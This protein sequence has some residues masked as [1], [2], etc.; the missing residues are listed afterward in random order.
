MKASAFWGA[1]VRVPDGAGQLVCPVPHREQARV[2]AWHDGL[3]PGVWEALLCWAK[4]SAKSFTAAAL[5][6]H[7][8]VGEDR[9]PDD[10]LIGI[11]SYD[12]EQSRVIF[13]EVRR[14]IERAPILR[15][16]LRVLRNEIV[17]EEVATDARTGGRYTRD[18][19]LRV[20]SRDV[21]GTHGEPWSM[22]IR[23]E[24][25]SEPNHEMSEALIPS[26]ARR[27]ACT[28]S[29]SYAGLATMQKPG[30]P[31]YD[32]LARATAGD[33]RLFASYIGGLGED[34][35]WRVC[36]WITED[37]I[38]AQRALFT[39]S[40]SRFRRVVLNVPVASDG[41]GL[42]TLAEIQAAIDPT[43]PA[44][45][46]RQPA[47]YVGAL[48]L[49]VSN[50]HSA[51]VIGHLDGD[52]RFVVDV[53]DVWRPR[54]G[55]PVAL[56]E[57]RERVA[58]WH[59]R[60]PVTTLRVD[61]WNAKLLVE[62]LRRAGVPATL[63]GVEQGRLNQII[64]VMKS[65]FST[66]AIRLA[67]TQTYLLEQLEALKVLETRSPRRDLLKFAPSGTGLDASQ[68]D[69]AAVALGLCLIE[70]K[71]RL[72]RVTLEEMPDGCQSQM[73]WAYQ[74]LLNG[75]D[76]MPADRL[77]H[78]HCPGL[79]S[80]KALYQ[81]H[82]TRTGQPFPSYRE[83]LHSGLVGPNRHLTAKRLWRL[84]VDLGF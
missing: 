33:P 38:E 49:G 60:L 72:G 36:P 13:A 17:Y 24:L 58:A 84:R 45:V 3:G 82:E 61:Q 14:L 62:D 47:T 29:C 68:H 70:V 52:G 73:D 26:P 46:T 19:R 65:A 9:E 1:A 48:D 69:D 16:R 11:A 75:G 83:F 22:V 64:T 18:H 77:C 30:V 23:D 35:S 20:L 80:L 55:E 21:K 81:R 71:D 2:L 66:R 43:L 78:R 6:L 42:L 7:H 5:G 51:L 79:I 56:T 37:W 15:D 8:L 4:K 74:C 25:W 57:V 54:P 27:F 34:A 53:C 12:E 40:P 59:R 28:V 44:V 67:P 76:L 31:L 50:D 63:I 32:L 41:D 10:R 39:A